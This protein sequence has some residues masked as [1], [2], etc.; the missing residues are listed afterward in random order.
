V[1]GHEQVN[2]LV[3]DDQPANL[4]A[5]EAVLSELGENLVFAGSGE[6]AVE[7]GATQDYA[8]ILLDVRMPTMSGFDAARVLRSMPRTRTTPIIFVTAFSAGDIDVEEAYGL[9]GIDFLSKPIVPTVLK[10]KVR[11]FG[12]LHRRTAEL[13]RER[14]FLAAVLDAVEDGIVAC[15]AE[16]RLTLFNRA[17]RELHA[18]SADQSLT[19]EGWS[20]RYK[21]FKADGF[22]PLPTHEIPLV[23]ALGGERVRDAEIVVAPEAGPPRHMRASASPLYEEGGRSLGAV[24]SMHDVSA[25]RQAASLAQTDRRKD[26]FLATLAHELRNPL[27]PLRNGLELLKALHDKPAESE[28]ARAMMERQLGHMVHLVDDLLDAAR[29][30]RGSIELKRERVDLRSVV[31][32]AIETSTP[33]IQSAQHQL[34]VDVPADA[35][36]VDVDALRMAQVFSN[37][38]NNAAK[39]TDMGGRIEVALRTEGPDALVRVSDN[40]VGIPSAALPTVF[41]LFQQVPGS[42]EKSQGGLGIGLSV[43]RRL[44]ELHGG[45]VMATS[46]APGKGSSFVIRLPRGAE[47]TASHV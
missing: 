19:V 47:G 12:E 10:A 11:F 1:S 25:E 6:E 9:G 40:G 4:M 2:I 17:S 41:E 8:A 26:E 46:E 20:M 13:A 33:L 21:L 15:D 27:A 42:E 45:S 37:L 36:W 16:G 18:A 43:V 28:K 31:E 24:V 30:T 5:M 32:R 34:H 29:I 35:V 14:A 44:V 38:L 22:T 39:Y 23:R 3:V 7:L